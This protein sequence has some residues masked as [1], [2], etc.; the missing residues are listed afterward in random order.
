TRLPRRAAPNAKSWSGLAIKL[1]RWQRTTR[2]APAKK[3]RCDPP[4]KSWNERERSKWQPCEQSGVK[5]VATPLNLL[6]CPLSG[7]SGHRLVRCKCLLL[8]HRVIFLT[9]H[10]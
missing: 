10:I 8:T 1:R 7:E 4:S 6:K 9:R 2:N 5:R 3:S